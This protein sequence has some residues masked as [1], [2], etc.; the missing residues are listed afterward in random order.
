MPQVL[1]PL[2]SMLIGGVHKFATC[3]QITR[4]DSVVFRFTDHNSVLTVDGHQYSPVGS[5]SASANERKDGTSVSNFEVKSFISDDS[6][7]F[8]DL[9]AGRF[10]D[11]T[12]IEFLVNWRYPWEGKF[13]IDQYNVVETTFTGEVWNWSIENM[14][15]RLKRK[16][17]RVY[18]RNCGY[19]YG[20]P[21]TCKKTKFTQSGTVATIVETDRIMLMTM[22]SKPTDFFNDGTIIW[23]TGNNAGLKSEVKYSVTPNL[24]ELH[25]RTPFPAQV[26]DTF[27]IEDGCEHTKSACL[28]KSNMNNYGGF[29]TIP[30]ND[31]LYSTPNAH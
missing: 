7:T 20:D 22:T 8:E 29:W 25:L 28:G 1:S 21:D 6:I 12:I 9:V 31:R 26:G 16:V 23:L 19:V 10:R 24:V 13:Q 14:K 30:G 18:S 17:G 3:W 5:P 2:A 4:T 11:A 15:T 27:D